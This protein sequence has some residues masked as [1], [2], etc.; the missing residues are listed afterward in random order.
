MTACSRRLER[1][2]GGARSATARARRSSLRLLHARQD[3]GARRA[4]REEIGFRQQRAFGGAAPRIAGQNRIGGDE[5]GDHVAGQAFGGGELVLDRSCP[6]I[7]MSMMSNMLARLGIAYSPALSS[8]SCGAG[9][10]RTRRAA[11]ILRSRRRPAVACAMPCR[12]MPGVISTIGFGRAVGAPGPAASKFALSHSKS[13]GG[14]DAPA[15]SRNARKRT[16]ARPH[17]LA[18]LGEDQ[19]GIGA[20]EAEGVGHA[21]PSP[22]ASWRER[23]EIELASRRRDCRD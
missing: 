20:A 3:L 8:P 9:A 4:A 11:A 7:R 19:R 1:Q 2:A 6:T 12:P 15:T 13:A 17:R 23:H 18:G 14:D 10:R 16:M 5:L 21:S 22:R